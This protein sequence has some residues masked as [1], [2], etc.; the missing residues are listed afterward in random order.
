MKKT[1]VTIEGGGREVE[2]T[3]EDIAKLAEGMGTV[4]CE[5][6][7]GKRIRLEY[8]RSGRCKYRSCPHWAMGREA[9]VMEKTKDAACESVLELMN[10]DWDQFQDAIER[11]D[12]REGTMN[13]SVKVD[14]GAEGR[15]ELTV[16]MSFVKEKR[17]WKIEKTVNE[18]QLN[19]LDGGVSG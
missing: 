14:A 2:T 5:R 10:K 9:V 1:P 18:N 4:W 17:K 16:A 6:R 15:N 11:S 8:C 19:L 3:V 7:K 13:I 12:K